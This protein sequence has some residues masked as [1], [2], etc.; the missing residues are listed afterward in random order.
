MILNSSNFR[1]L[2]LTFL[3]VDAYDSLELAS[4]IAWVKK[5]RSEVVKMQN[6]RSFLFCKLI[7][8][9]DL[10]D[11][12]MQHKTGNLLV[13]AGYIVAAAIQHLYEPRCR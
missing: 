13:R 2:K 8:K 5:F 1:V 7:Y 10:V 4:R 3:T 12:I 6:K 11:L 9:F